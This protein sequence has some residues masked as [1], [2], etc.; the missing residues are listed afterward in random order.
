MHTVVAHLTAKCRR[1]QEHKG[2]GYRRGCALAWMCSSAESNKSSNACR[3][4]S[5]SLRLMGSS[6]WSSNLP[7]RWAIS[8]YSILE[9]LEHEAEEKGGVQ[10][11]LAD[12]FAKVYKVSMSLAA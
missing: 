1:Y 8:Y 6:P 7:T 3:C 4:S 12:H 11:L 9:A 10:Q 5:V 2:S